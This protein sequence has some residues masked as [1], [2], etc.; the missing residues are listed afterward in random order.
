MSEAETLR[1]L[2]VQPRLHPQT[3]MGKAATIIGAVLAVVS[4]IAGIA[5]QNPVW[6]IGFAA[7]LALVYRDELRT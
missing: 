1:H 3:L 5:S 4:V 6:I 2:R 7:G